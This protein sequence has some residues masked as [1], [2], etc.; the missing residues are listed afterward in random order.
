MQYRNNGGKRLNGTDA[1]GNDC[2]KDKKSLGAFVRGIESAHSG[3]QVADGACHLDVIDG[4][5]AQEVARWA[6]AAKVT[7]D[8]EQF[9]IACVG[10]RPIPKCLRHL[11]V[12]HDLKRNQAQA[13]LQQAQLGP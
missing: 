1:H 13:R 10:N 6:L 12:V 5:A 3:F 7:Q 8:F 2:E 11:K 4:D 9:F